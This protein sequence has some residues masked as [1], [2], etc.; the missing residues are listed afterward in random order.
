MYFVFHLHSLK[1]GVGGNKKRATRWG[2]QSGRFNN[3]NGKIRRT[4]HFISSHQ[5]PLLLTSH[6]VDK[7]KLQ[8]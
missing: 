5:R 4:S 6:Y 8:V 7:Q 2:S 1:R 3:Y